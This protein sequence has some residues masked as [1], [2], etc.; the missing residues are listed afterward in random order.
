MNRRQKL[1][2]IK[3]EN[4]YLLKI[5]NNSDGM[6]DLLNAF[7]Q[8]LPVIHDHE[9][10]KQYRIVK[11]FAVPNEWDEDKILDILVDGIEKELHSVIKEN[12]QFEDYGNGSALEF[13]DGK[14]VKATF[15]LWVKG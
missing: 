13:R 14:E 9:K 15:N 12:M 11:C 6:R 5:I 7:K 1:K 8:P 3:R 2:K 10:L 4:E